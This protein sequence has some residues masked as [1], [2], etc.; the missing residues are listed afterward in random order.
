MPAN[1]GI[2]IEKVSFYLGLS[3]NLWEIMGNPLQ[4]GVRLMPPWS[5]ATK[6]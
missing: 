1:C 3:G 2:L 5:S 6:E 4:G